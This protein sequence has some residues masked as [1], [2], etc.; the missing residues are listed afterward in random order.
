MTSLETRDFS[1][2]SKQLAN[3]IHTEINFL[4]L[5]VIEIFNFQYESNKLS[6]KLTEREMKLTLDTVLRK[7]I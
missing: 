7:A 5:V 4:L 6:K 3:V 1:I 2:L